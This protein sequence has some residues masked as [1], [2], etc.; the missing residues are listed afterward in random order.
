AA[1]RRDGA[2]APARPRVGRAQAGRG[3]GE[4]AVGPLRPPLA[5]A[6]VAA[7]PHQ[8]PAVGGAAAGDGQAAA[9]GADRV[10]GGDGPALG[11]TGDAGLEL[12]VGA[13]GGPVTRVLQALARERQGGPGRG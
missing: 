5:G 3:V 1:P 11:G 7:G 6:A 8:L 2:G 9:V 13:V 10:V 4:L 12:D